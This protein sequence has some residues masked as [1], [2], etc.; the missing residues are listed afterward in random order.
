MFSQNME[1]SRV[2]KL[3]IHV[4]TSHLTLSKNKSIS[5]PHLRMKYYDCPQECH[6]H[7]RASE[8]SLPDQTS[9]EHRLFDQERVNTAARERHFSSLPFHVDWVRAAGDKEDGEKGKWQK[10]AAGIEFLLTVSSGSLFHWKSKSSVNINGNVLGK[11]GKLEWRPFIKVVWDLAWRGRLQAGEGEVAETASLLPC[12]PGK[13]NT[14][15]IIC[16]FTRWRCSD[17]QGS[18]STRKM[19]AWRPGGAASLWVGPSARSVGRARWGCTA[20]K[21]GLAPVCLCELW[22]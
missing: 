5:K 12:L 22:R 16:A 18:R 20:H 17:D 14:Q 7:G 21:P 8:G 15:S 13:I 6:D 9:A 3:L 19:A 4:P 11:I 10:G 2:N 1:S